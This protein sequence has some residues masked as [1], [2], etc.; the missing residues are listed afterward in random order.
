MVKT[1]TEVL[2]EVAGLGQ[3]FQARSRSFSLYGPPS[4]QITYIIYFF[5]AV[6]WLTSGFV[7]ATLSLNRLTCRRSNEAFVK[8]RTSERARKQNESILIVKFLLRWLETLTVSSTF[9][10]LEFDGS[11]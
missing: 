7:Y 5:P 6:N 9:Q 2:P 8:N 1:V 10:D 11:L 4:R 3:H